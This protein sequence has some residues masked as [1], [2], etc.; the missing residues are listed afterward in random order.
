MPE[1]SLV[2]AEQN[3]AVA[4]IQPQIIE[5]SESPKISTVSVTFLGITLLVSSFI[6]GYFMYALWPVLENTS[7]LIGT[8]KL[9]S[10]ESVSYIFGQPY[11]FSAE[12]RLLILVLLAGAMGSFIHAATSFSNYVGEGKID[13]K[14]IWWYILRPI[15]GMA[16]ALTFYMIFR[17]GLFAGM[18]IELLNIYGVLTLAALSGLFTD[19]A[20]LKLEEIFQSLF[21]P[22]DE[23]ADKLKATKKNDFEDPQAQA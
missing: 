4:V 1:E 15:I 7:E 20:T 17:A 18:Q 9:P 10:W 22:K 13:K 23:R 2:P 6:I 3:V 14:W 16:V 8:G 19:R 12:Q 11:A 21:K 5:D